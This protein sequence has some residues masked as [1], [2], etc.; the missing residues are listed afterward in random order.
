MAWA[1]SGG[2]TG[3]VIRIDICERIS[4]RERQL[5]VEAH[6]QPTPGEKVRRPQNGEK[7]PRGAPEGGKADP[8]Y[9]GGAKQPT[10]IRN[11]SVNRP[12][13][14]ALERAEPAVAPL[15]GASA[16]HWTAG[17]GSEP[18]PRPIDPAGHAGARGG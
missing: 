7:G 18:S 13:G 8:D 9:G 2:R 4:C 10:H 12:R 11:P 17:A 14:G 15:P 5:R 1:L 16:T 6:T 3:Q